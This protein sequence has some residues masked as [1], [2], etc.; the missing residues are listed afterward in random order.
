[1]ADA[2][3]AWAGTYHRREAGRLL[4]L[5]LVRVAAAADDTPQLEWS[6]D[7]LASTARASWTH[8]GRG[9]A[10]ARRGPDLVEFAS[11]FGTHTLER[12]GE[13]LVE[14]NVRENLLDRLLLRGPTFASYTWTRIEGG[15]IEGAGFHVGAMPG[16]ALPGPAGAPAPPREPDPGGHESAREGADP[17]CSVQ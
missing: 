3:E 5:H 1:M 7:E 8:H 11:R 12:V 4:A 2:A 10:L 17:R 16:G 15:C 14:Q 9:L 13:T 6:I